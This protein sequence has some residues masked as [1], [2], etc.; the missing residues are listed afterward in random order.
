MITTAAAYYL[1][2]SQVSFMLMGLDKIAACARVRRVPGRTLVCLALLGG[3][4]GILV[5]A[6]GF[7]HKIRK[8][9]FLTW[10]GALSVIHLAVVIA[11]V[12]QLH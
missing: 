8:P 10:A 11:I 5:G 2:L 4:P 9:R 1:C 12:L 3:G 6:L 7:R